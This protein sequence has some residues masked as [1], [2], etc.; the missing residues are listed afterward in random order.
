[1]VGWEWRSILNNE[2]NAVYLTYLVWKITADALHGNSL[3]CFYPTV[4]LKIYGSC[5]VMAETDAC[6]AFVI[7]NHTGDDK[8]NYLDK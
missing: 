5:S 1:M 8:Q 3:C 7:V 6:I 4:N 2:C